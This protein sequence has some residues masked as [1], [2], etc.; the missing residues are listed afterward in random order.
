MSTLGKRVSSCVAVTIVWVGG[1]ASVQL[2]FWILLTIVRGREETHAQQRWLMAA[3]PLVVCAG[4]SLAVLLIRTIS[5]WPKL[6]AGKLFIRAMALSIFSLLLFPTESAAAVAGA[7][8]A[9]AIAGAAIFTWQAAGR[10]EL[11]THVF[12]DSTL[13]KK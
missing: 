10:G 4:G 6:P 3:V 9:L 7:A 12:P 13:V 2:P 1:C 8:N 5:G 11:G